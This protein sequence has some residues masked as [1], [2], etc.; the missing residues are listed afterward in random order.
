MPKEGK[1][2]G[3][4]GTIGAVAMSGARSFL[5]R[6]MIV[7]VRI[8]DEE[9]GLAIHGE[10]KI[11]PGEV[12]VVDKVITKK[13]QT[14]SITSGSAIK[15]AATKYLRC[16]TSSREALCFPFAH[17]GRFSILV[18]KGN[19]NYNAVYKIDQLL[20][21]FDFPLTVRLV[22]GRPPN[23]ECSFSGILRLL[24]IYRSET[25]VSLSLTP[26]K[27]ML[28]EIPA[29]VGIKIVLV[30]RRK[31]N[32]TDEA[33]QQAKDICERSV[34]DY[35]TAMKVMETMKPAKTVD[36]ENVKVSVPQ[37]VSPE[38]PKPN[39][40]SPITF[41][42]DIWSYDTESEH[43]YDSI[44][45]V[46]IDD[47][48]RSRRRMSGISEMD[49]EGYLK[50]WEA[51]TPVRKTNS[52]VSVTG[53]ENIPA[54]NKTRQSGDYKGT[55]IELDTFGFEQVVQ[56]EYIESPISLANYTGH[57]EPVERKRV[58]KKMLVPNHDRQV[59]HS[60]SS[61][62]T[63]SGAFS[64]ISGD[65]DYVREPPV[66]SWKPPRDITSLSIR[67]VSRCLRYI[68]IGEDSVKKFG[69]DLVDGAMLSYMGELTLKEG[70][71]ELNEFE[72]HKI[73]RFIQGWR[74]K[75]L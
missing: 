29:D 55:I 65:E 56:C 22:F 25:L 68:G 33:F 66:D 47:V 70:F 4:Y 41:H 44:S 58:S 43:L 32:I 63:D 73:S 18:G 26:R 45:D 51:R 9:S 54:R 19:M 31:E 16:L 2:V 27:Y 8:S 52:F 3:H 61:Q 17:P 24:E 20:E 6:T 48:M 57:I 49:E 10:C 34:C 46:I 62:T 59:S 75:Q 11:K 7:G 36:G 1:K 21:D 42:A 15:E 72:R 37:I 50:P 5:V 39:E 67:D 71:P 23:T 40:G 74:P 60:P 53:Y 12:L 38:L 14:T 28:L 69:D 64:Q 35:V 13:W 30:D